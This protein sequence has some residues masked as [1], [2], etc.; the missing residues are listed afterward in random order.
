MAHAFGTEKTVGAAAFFSGEVLPE[1][2]LR[3]TLNQ[4]LYVGEL[5]EGTSARVQQLVSALTRAGIQGEVGAML[6]VQAPM[7]RM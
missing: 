3:F 1:G 4:G 6:Q 2:P 5:P 7:N